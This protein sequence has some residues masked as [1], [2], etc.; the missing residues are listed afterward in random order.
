[1]K[2]QELI[3]HFAE[4]MDTAVV[5][6]DTVSGEHGGPHV[7]YANPAFSRM[8]GYGREEVIGGTPRILQGKETN[9]QRTK[10]LARAVKAGQ[11]HHTMFVNYRKNGEKYHCEVC[12]FP[13]E[14]DAGETTHFIAFE[15]EAIR[16]PGRPK[17]INAH[18]FWWI[19]DWAESIAPSAQPIH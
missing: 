18:D 8:T 16:K 3:A 13:I 10:A 2:L 12:A 14:N 5:L 15:R 6:T 9:K 4:G 11:M 1:M 19:P 17:K 7:L